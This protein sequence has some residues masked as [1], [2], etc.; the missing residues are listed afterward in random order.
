[1]DWI[2]RPLSI[3]IPSQA[4]MMSTDHPKQSG[5]QILTCNQFIFVS[6][7]SLGHERESLI[8]VKFYDQTSSQLRFCGTLGFL[9]HEIFY[10]RFQH[11]RQLCGLRDNTK[12]VLLEISSQT[13]CC[14]IDVSNTFKQEDLR[15]GSIV[16][17]Q[18]GI[19]TKPISK[20]LQLRPQ[21]SSVWEP[22]CFFINPSNVYDRREVVSASSR[23]YCIPTSS[24]CLTRNFR[25]KANF[26]W[27]HIRM[28][29][30][31]CLI[32]ELPLKAE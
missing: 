23:Q 21:I 27:P 2:Q 30:Q 7:S 13:S 17:A 20:E 16:V 22:R 6:P 11:F 14:H 31:L 24:L 15:M 3:S 19:L 28:C 29:L 10:A 25:V 12:I 18:E 4:F 9:D 32:L 5:P 8:F 1:M 26:V